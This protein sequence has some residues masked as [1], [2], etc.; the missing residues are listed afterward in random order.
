MRNKIV[1]FKGGHKCDNSY[2]PCHKELL[3]KEKFASSGS[4]FCPLREV[5]VMKMDAFEDNHCLSSS[6]LLMCVFFQRSGYA[7]EHII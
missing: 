3:F 2:F 5:P 1:I 6:L 7:T 4:N